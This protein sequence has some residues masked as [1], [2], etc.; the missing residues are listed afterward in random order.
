MIRRAFRQ[1]PSKSSC[2]SLKAIARTLFLNHTQN[3]HFLPPSSS[4]RGAGSRRWKYLIVSGS[5][6]SSKRTEGLTI[7]KKVLGY[8]LCPINHPIVTSHPWG[9]T[10]SR[11]STTLVVPSLVYERRSNGR[12]C[13]R[14]RSTRVRSSRTS[15]APLEYCWSLQN[16]SIHILASSV[17]IQTQER[18]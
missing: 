6:S 5:G 16:R 8:S 10:G 4:L 12:Y 2:P 15:D 13:F 9:H 18:L 3:H 17:L 7:I 14:S 1:A 11:H